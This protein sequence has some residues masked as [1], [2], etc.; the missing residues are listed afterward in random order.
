M[1]KQVELWLHHAKVDLLSAKKLLEDENLTQSVAFHCHQ[2]VE[3]SFKALL[4]NE[5]KRFTKTHDLQNLYGL[6]QKENI[7]LEIDEDALTQI[8]DVY[9][10]SRY[11]GDTGLIPNGIPSLKKAN[12]FYDLSKTVYEKVRQILK[13]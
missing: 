12:E 8:N 1:K 6:I 5:D 13:K 9:I 7:Q 3:K 4:E 10:D 2:A 11:P